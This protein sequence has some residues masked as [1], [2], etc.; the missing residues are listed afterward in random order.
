VA[1]VF[2][3][4]DIFGHKITSEEKLAEITQN[5]TQAIDDWQ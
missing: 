4:K 2:Y 3:I 5:L 1:D